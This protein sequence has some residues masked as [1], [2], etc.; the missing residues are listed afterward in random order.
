MKQTKCRIEMKCQKCDKKATMHITDLVGSKP[1]ELHLCAEH[2]QEYLA[3]TEN[4][5]SPVGGNMA[6][7]LAAQMAQQMAFSK[8][9]DEFSKS[10]QETC[11]ICGLTFF[12]FRA[13]SRLG[14]PEDYQ[15]FRK[16]LTPLLMNIH[17]E[18]RHT[19]KRPSCFGEED[20]RKLTALIGYRR[21]M[22]E[23]IET[24]SYEKAGMLRDKI[25]KLESE[26]GIE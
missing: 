14:C 2:A 9:S 5:M 8:V 17:G 23:A 20:A 24:E 1:V 22:S 3:Q 11:P 18:C 7:A 16:Q 15:T 25:R 26:A 21:E 6:S 19:G 12:E 10:D 13:N 4:G